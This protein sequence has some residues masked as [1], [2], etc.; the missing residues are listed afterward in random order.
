MKLWINILRVFIVLITIAFEFVPALFICYVKRVF[1]LAKV[2][3]YLIEKNEE[4]VR[5]M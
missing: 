3:N 2:I 1:L 4:V 5:K